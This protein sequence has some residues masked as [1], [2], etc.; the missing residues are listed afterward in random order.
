[1]SAVNPK[2]PIEI[3]NLATFFRNS[4]HPEVG[5]IVPAVFT[6]VLSKQFESF[7]HHQLH[8]ESENCAVTAQR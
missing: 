4:P 1:M 6:P 5:N 7:F 3:S 2:F 8:F